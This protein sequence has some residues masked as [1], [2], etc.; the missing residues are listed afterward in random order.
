MIIIISLSCAEWSSC[1]EVVRDIT[2]LRLC[3]EIEVVLLSNLSLNLDVDVLEIVD[4]KGF[5]LVNVEVLGS[6][7][8]NFLHSLLLLLLSL[9]MSLAMCTSQNLIVSI[10]DIKLHWMLIVGKESVVSICKISQS[11]S[12]YGS[13]STISH[14]PNRKYSQL[15]IDSTLV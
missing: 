3:V 9:L 4:A 6:L 5:A 14:L 7:S 2:I 1:L 8:N 13:F 12:L 11:S 15:E 10:I